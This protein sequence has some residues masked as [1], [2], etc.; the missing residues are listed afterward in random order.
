M[1]A[2]LEPGVWGDSWRLLAQGS[3]GATLTGGACAALRGPCALLASAQHD[4]Y[5]T[6]V[7]RVWL[8][9]PGGITTGR[10]GPR[11][12]FSL[13]QPA[14]WVLLLIMQVLE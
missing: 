8:Q 12:G 5:P 3:S 14:D 9:R 6:C 2:S 10:A 11:S 4:L 7:N 13:S 1:A